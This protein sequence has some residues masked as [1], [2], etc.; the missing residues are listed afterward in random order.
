MHVMEASAIFTLWIYIVGFLVLTIQASRRAGRSVWLFGVGDQP[1]ALSALL[2]RLAFAIG[3]LHPTLSAAWA[4]LAEQEEPRSALMDGAHQLFGLAVM[5]SGAIFA[6]LA[7]AHMGTSWRIGAA[8]GHQGRIVDDGPFAVSRNPVFVGQ[9][10]LFMGS[11]VVFP[12]SIQAVVVLALLV[13]IHL[14]VKVE[15]QVLG[16]ELGQPYAD[17]RLRVRRWL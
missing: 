1:Q 2:F 11:L 12:S 15:E 3:A 8:E 6:L 4:V 13:A 7:Q 16:K 9:A 17:Y 10:A 5:A 14:Q